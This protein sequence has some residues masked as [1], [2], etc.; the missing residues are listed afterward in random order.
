[1]ETPI[2]LRK[3]TSYNIFVQKQSVILKSE[4]VVFKGSGTNFIYIAG[5]WN[6]YK[7]KEPILIESSEDDII[8]RMDFEIIKKRWKK[9]KQ[10]FSVMDKA[11]KHLADFRSGKIAGVLV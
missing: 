5:L 6:I 9:A 11:Q 1:M 10:E 3:L 4:G 2:S 8:K 7:N